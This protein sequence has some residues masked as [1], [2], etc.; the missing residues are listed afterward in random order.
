MKILVIIRDFFSIGGAENFARDFVRF[1]KLKGNDV[2]VLTT[3]KNFFKKNKYVLK[4]VKIVQFFV[5]KIRFLGTIIY[6]I[7]VSF[8]LIF[9]YKEFDVIQSFFLK[10]SSF[11]SILI[12][13]LLRKRV[14]CRDEC[15]GKFGDI[16]AIKKLPF[17]K[18]FLNVFKKA[19]GIIVLSNEMKR[20]LESY[21]FKKE[22]L[23]LIPNAVDVNKF[24]PS[25]QKEILKTKFGYKGE[26]IIIYAGR[27]TEQKGVEYL[28]R[29]FRELEI[30]EK[31]LII[32]GEGDLK[33]KLEKLTLELR[34][35]D[36]VLFLGKKENIIPYLQI[37][38]LFVLPSLGEGLPIV[39]L[40]AMACGLPVVVSKVGGNI[41]IVEDGINGYLIEPG[42]I[43]QIK[44]AIEDLLKNE[45]K[46]KK[47]GEINRKKIERDYSFEVII[48]R[49]LKLYNKILK[50]V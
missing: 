21:N 29:S 17:Y 4:D 5:P 35:S 31:L 25:E 39:L 26:K 20:E 8:Y 19:D 32:L 36:S 14:F 9:H 28:I 40:E 49:Y 27:L 47:I 41:D 22:K 33:N 18:I 1:L 10:H 6:Y 12:G 16:E 34:I 44:N 3:R 45:E 15:S 7:D 38:D 50:P 11:I 23:F 37:S 13:K 43:Y 46:I 2:I 42:N 24:K 30:K 48:E